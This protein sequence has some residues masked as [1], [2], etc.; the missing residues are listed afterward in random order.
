MLI[1]LGFVPGQVI[2]IYS[3]LKK[4]NNNKGIYFKI[5]FLLNSMHKRVE[6]VFLPFYAWRGYFGN[7][8]KPCGVIYRLRHDSL[9]FS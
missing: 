6:I 7:T 8:L 9:Y 2:A 4:I 1:K 3:T 5:Y